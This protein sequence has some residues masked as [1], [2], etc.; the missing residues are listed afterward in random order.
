M[1][2][3]EGDSVFKLLH[4]SA[5]SLSDFQFT[6]TSLQRLRQLVYLYCGGRT[7]SDPTFIDTFRLLSS[8]IKRVYF[9]HKYES[10]NFQAWGMDGGKL[11]LLAGDLQAESEIAHD[12]VSAVQEGL[13]PALEVVSLP[14]EMDREALRTIKRLGKKHHFEIIELRFRSS[15]PNR[16]PTYAYW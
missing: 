3:D 14:C 9:G 8:R 15:T 4:S 6:V 16:V 12:L 11:G 7:S 13:L 1:L 5:E 10:R 2:E